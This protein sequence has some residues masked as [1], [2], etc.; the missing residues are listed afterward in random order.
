MAMQ[1]SILKFKGSLGDLSFYNSKYG[2]I[3]RKKG[4]PSAH[5]IETLPSF[6]KTREHLAEFGRAGK[7]AKLIRQAFNLRLSSAADYLMTGRLVKALHRIVKSDTKHRSG[8]RQVMSGQKELLT[9]FQFNKDATQDLFLMK[10]PTVNLD[11]FAGNIAVEVAAFNPSV[12]LAKPQA[13]THFRMVVTAGAFDFN[14]E[15]YTK[16]TTKSGFIPLD[17]PLQDGLS[18]ATSLDARN[19]PVLVTMAVQFV[20]LVNGRHHPIQ[21]SRHDAMAII[22]I[23]TNRIGSPKERIVVRRLYQLT[24]TLSNPQAQ[25]SIYPSPPS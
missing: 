9:G 18:L 13:A 14:S 25:L 20:Q 10:S 5:K 2:Y 23:D 7:A 21:S 3:V 16:A 17:S 24:P 12:A 8:K 6:R 11:R 15:K 19:K 22:H 4:G 1:D